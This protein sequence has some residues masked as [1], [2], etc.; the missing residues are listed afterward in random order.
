MNT[1]FS[2]RSSW[3]L[4][5]IWRPDTAAALFFWEQPEVY[6][7]ICLYTQVID[8][9]WDVRISIPSLDPMK[10]MAD[11]SN[12][13]ELLCADFDEKLEEFGPKWH[14]ETVLELNLIRL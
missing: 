7:K 2:A 8:L 10:I 3:R 5:C 4:K 13:K 14:Q 6:S 9:Y 1:A 12:L 11:S